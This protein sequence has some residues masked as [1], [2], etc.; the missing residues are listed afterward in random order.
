MYCACIKVNY[1]YLDSEE[2]MEDHMEQ[3]ISLFDIILS[4]FKNVK[5][6]VTIE[7]KHFI[8]NFQ[9]CKTK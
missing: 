7:G 4:D 3:T 5:E 2:P 6:S 8:P 1:L 9:Y